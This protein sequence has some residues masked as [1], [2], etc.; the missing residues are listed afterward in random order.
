[1]IRRMRSHEKSHIRRTCRRLVRRHRRSHF[2]IASVR[3]LG[4]PRRSLTRHRLCPAHRC[5]LRGGIAALEPFVSS[6]SPEA[7]QA[8][9][10]WPSSGRYSLLQYYYRMSS[11]NAAFRA[12][13]GPRVERWRLT[14]A[15]FQIVGP[16]AALKPVSFFEQ[17]ITKEIAVGRLMNQATLAAWLERLHGQSLAMRANCR[18]LL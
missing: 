3:I 8:L 1:M 5:A 9:V 7:R 12:T 2:G 18:A 14:C 11:G 16:E 15:A 17:V 13:H 6:A 10:Y 4:D